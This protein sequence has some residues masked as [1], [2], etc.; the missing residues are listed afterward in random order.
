MTRLRNFVNHTLDTR[1]TPLAYVFAAH[2]LALAIGFQIVL[3]I[4]WWVFVVAFATGLL[5]WG[6]LNKAKCA[7]KFASVVMFAAWVFA[8][9]LT[10]ITKDYTLT[11][12]A[13]STVLCYGYYYLAASLGRL[14]NY[15]PDRS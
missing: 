14:W 10:L 13:F 9:V 12:L 6:L 1:V 4:G 15:T 3:N 7:I 2:G 5:I 8:G 11:P